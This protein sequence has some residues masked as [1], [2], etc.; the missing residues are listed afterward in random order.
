VGKVTER[1]CVWRRAHHSIPHQDNDGGHG[2]DA[3]FAHPTVLDFQVGQRK[4]AAAPE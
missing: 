2:A 4:S 1:E 3:P